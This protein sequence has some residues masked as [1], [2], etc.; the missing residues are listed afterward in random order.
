MR[1]ERGHSFP[2]TSEI[3]HGKAGKGAIAVLPSWASAEKAR[4]LT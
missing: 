2:D 1:E 3:T 4:R